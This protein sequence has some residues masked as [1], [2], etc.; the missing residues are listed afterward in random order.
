MQRTRIGPFALEE[1]L[2]SRGA[3]QVVRGLHL[4]RKTAMAVKLLPPSLVHQPM[5]GNLFAAD[6]KRLQR[7][8]LP[9]VVRC[10]GGAI[11]E[12]QPYLVLELVSGESLRDLL[13]RRGK[14]PWELAVEL[15]DG[16]CQSLQQAHELGFVHQRLAPS[17]IL[18]PADGGV[19]LTGF[20]CAWADRD[21]VLGLRSSM[22]VAPY[23]APEVFRG[24]QSATLPPGDLFSLGVILYQCLTGKLPWDAT[25]PSELVQARRGSAAPRVAPQVLDCPVWLDVLVA[26]LLQVKRAERIS[27][28]DEVHRAMVTALQKGAA[29]MGTV[30]QA[31]SGQ[32]GT[33]SV[34]TDRRELARLKQGFRRKKRDT[35]PFYEKIWFLGLCLVAL[36]AGGIWSLLPADEHTLFERARPYMDSDSPVDWKRA[37]EQYLKPL[38]EHYP[39]TEYAAEIEAFEDR[40]RMYRGQTRAKNNTRLGRPAESEAERIYSEAWDSEKR[41]DRITAWQRYEAPTSMFA[42]SEEPFDRAFAELGRQ[43]IE[44]LRFDSG[45]KSQADFVKEQLAASRSLIESGDLFQARRILDGI[46]TSYRDNRELQ[47]LVD[48]ARVQIQRLAGEE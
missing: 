18:L 19:K 24:K 13:E 6:V 35:S 10:L 43:R 4:E 25:T 14:L 34:P 11:E 12:G 39:E 28:A 36:V 26:K 7:L 21:E 17:R 27:S 16:I 37:E 8:V 31:L 29:G 45:G 32:R 2:D 9:G 3:A 22:E 38:L 47:P 41:G 1:T 48:Q 42:T 30:Q 5:G 20:D 44:N 33:L 23:L 40:Y 46:V 15:A